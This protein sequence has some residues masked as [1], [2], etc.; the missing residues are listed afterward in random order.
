MKNIIY[1]ELRRRG[2]NVD[3]GIVEK[4]N[5]LDNGKKDYKQLEI[6]LM[7]NKGSDKYYIQSAYGIE[8]NNKKEQKLQSLLNVGDNFKKI[9]I[10]YDHFIKWQDDNGIIYMSIYDFLLNENSLKEA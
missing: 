1:T 10:V 4:R 3:V 5:N 6:D 7:V 2:F 8:D 9:V